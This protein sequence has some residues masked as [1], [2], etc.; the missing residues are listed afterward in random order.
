MLGK[1]VGPRV[2]LIGLV[3]AAAC[4]RTVAQDAN[5]AEDGKIKGAKAITLENGE[6][7]GK[8]IVTYPGGDRVDWKLIEVPDG[9]KGTLNFTLT[10]SSPRPGLKL[11]FDVF[12][13]FQHQLTS[14]K[15]ARAR[16]REAMVENAKGKYFVRIF[17][18]GRGDAG[19][20]T[21]NVEFKE[22]IAG[23]GFDVAKLDI[24]D[25]PKLAAV[26]EV[27]AGGGEEEKCD[28]FVWDIKKAAC[29]NICPAVGAPPGWPP[30]KGKCPNPPVATESACWATM[31]CPPGAPDEK[32]AD[33]KDKFPPCPDKAKP[34][35]R[36][37]NCRIPADPVV[38]RIVGKELKGGEFL[39]TVG[40]GE[41]QGV[42]KNWKGEVVR[43]NDVK[44]A[45]V[46]GGDVSIVRV[47]KSVT[48][49]RTKLSP[50]QV[51][52]T[53]YVRFSPK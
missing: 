17:A 12:D 9:K 31:P 26:P 20:Y 5:T 6:G 32:I 14:S 43:S 27:V 24:P 50:D 48:V 53:P 47:D 21:F 30:C 41:L 22:K 23:P 1:S 16:T 42:G 8:G 51:G 29:K 11:G 3:F 36:N 45:A 10:W 40:V 49:G 44:A 39:I 35:M 13:E 38:G 37:P 46:P 4:A 33:C 15:R 28:E 18:V 7:K 2:L 52:S 19:K 34:D 25:P